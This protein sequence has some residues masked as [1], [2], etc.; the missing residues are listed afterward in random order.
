MSDRTF[1]TTLM[2]ALTTVVAHFLRIDV[3]EL[4]GLLCP[5]RIPSGRVVH[6]IVLYDDTPGGSGHV[7]QIVGHVEE[8]V[9]EIRDLLRGTPEHDRTCEAACAACLISYRTQFHA[10][11]LDRHVV[12]ACL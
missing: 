6:D 7:A 4:G 9:N 3:R 1:A 2:A 10:P 8:L 11:H 5:H 12:L